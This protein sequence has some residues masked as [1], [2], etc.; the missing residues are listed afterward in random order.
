[1]IKRDAA[2]SVIKD[3]AK[4]SISDKI[5]KEKAYEIAKNLKHDW[6]QWGLAGMIH[7]TFDKK[8]GSTVKVSVS[9]ELSQ[10][11]HKLLIK[12]I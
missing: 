6:Y 10:E 12:K 8:T 7:N 3:L 4:R 1:M 5:L 2:Y 9:E 11:L